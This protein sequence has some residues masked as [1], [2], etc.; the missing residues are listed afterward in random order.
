MED[1]K[2]KQEVITSYQKKIK[3]GKLWRVISLFLLLTAC[4]SGV[5]A[6]TLVIMGVWGTVK[7]DM[8]VII[9]LYGFILIL[10]AVMA[11]LSYWLVK[12]CQRYNN[13]ISRLN[14]L[15]TRYNIMNDNA[16]VNSN[17]DRDLQ[18]ISRLLES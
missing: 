6:M 15:I 17:L 12:S 13:A 2:G 5:V 10:I 9:L 14:A 3:R 11:C 4:L 7:K 18:L 1:M 8:P 16:M